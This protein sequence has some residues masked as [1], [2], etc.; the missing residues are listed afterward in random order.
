MKT[1]PLPKAEDLPD[2]QKRIFDSLADRG[3][4]SPAAATPTGFHL[5]PTVSGR[6]IRKETILLPGNG[7]SLQQN[8][9]GRAVHAA[10]TDSIS[11]SIGVF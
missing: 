4:S 7:I 8:R 3:A 10:A 2:C 1:S 6:E 5:K 11:R 9:C